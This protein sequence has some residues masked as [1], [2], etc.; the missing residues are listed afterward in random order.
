MIKKNLKKY[1]IKEK[2]GK[3]RMEIEGI[4]KVNLS[5]VLLILGIIVLLA[6][7]LMPKYSVYE[8]QM[9]GKAALS[10]AEYSRQIAVVEAEAKKNAA[11]ALAQAE[12]ERAKGVAE[13]NKII[14]ES[15]TEPYLRYLWIQGLQTNQMQVV[16]VPT[17]ANLPILE[18]S[19]KLGQFK[20]FIFFFFIFKSGH[21]YK[22][23]NKMVKT[24]KINHGIACRIGNTI[25]YNK[26][27]EHYPNL[28]QAIL[29]HEKKHTEGFTM[30]DIKMDLKNE[31]I[32]PFKK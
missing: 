10:Q 11:I 9:A 32:A 15:I 28:L 12:V 5:R 6:M 14:S 1:L 8:R 20:K 29:K 3:R 2:G 19:R 21:K 30:S 17:E 13:S 4:G 7:W 18:A 31:E 27:L 22:S 23:Q 24:K 16:Y 25:Y 26:A